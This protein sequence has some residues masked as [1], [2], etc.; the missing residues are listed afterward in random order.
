MRYAVEGLGDEALATERQ[1]LYEEEIEAQEEVEAQ[2]SGG[3]AARGA[4]EG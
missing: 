4:L 2:E 1:L 3:E